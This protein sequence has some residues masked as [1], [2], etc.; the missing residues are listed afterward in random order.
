MLM[1]SFHIFI[2]TVQRRA[3]EVSSKLKKV[4]SGLATCT[5]EGVESVEVDVGGDGDYDPALQYQQ[6]LSG[7]S[8]GILTD[9]N[10]RPQ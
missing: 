2:L 9:S 10:P 3:D 6:L 7:D 1:V 8:T 5:G 4:G